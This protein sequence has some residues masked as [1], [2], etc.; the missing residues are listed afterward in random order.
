[1]KF[2]ELWKE[3]PPEKDGV[4]NVVYDLAFKPDG[5]QLICGVGSRVLVFKTKTGALLH[6]LKGHRGAVYCVSYAANGKKFASG[7]A[8]NTIIIW[9]DKGEGVLKYSHN[10]SIQVMVYWR[11][12]GCFLPV[13]IPLSF[14]LQSFQVMKLQFACKASLGT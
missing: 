3:T 9:S 13:T 6:S 10:D 12:T 5:S 4:A 8:D 7:A 14:C 1:M 2:Q 11:E